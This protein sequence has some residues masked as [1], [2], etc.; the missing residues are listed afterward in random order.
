MH[1]TSAAVPCAARARTADKNTWAA[2]DGPL[3]LAASRLPAGQG[4]T[5]RVYRGPAT[6]TPALAGESAAARLAAQ[7][8]AERASRSAR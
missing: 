4:S 2:A 1:R 3:L 7:R 5:W 8:A 6:E